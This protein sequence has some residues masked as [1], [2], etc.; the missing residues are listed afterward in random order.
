MCPVLIVTN[1]YLFQVLLEDRE[2]IIDYN[3]ELIS[4]AQMID[5]VE[6]MGFD[7]TPKLSS[8]E[9]DSNVTKPISNP[10]IIDC[11]VQSSWQNTSVSRD[12]TLTVEGMRCKSC[13]RKIEGNM[14]DVPGVVHIA[15]SLESKC[16][17]VT[18]SEN[19]LGRDGVAQK[20]ADL[21]FQVTDS[22]G[23]MFKKEPLSPSKRRPGENTGSPQL[24]R[25][26][27]VA[28]ISPKGTELEMEVLH[29]P[30]K[31]TDMKRCFIEIKGMTCASCVN[32]IERH[33]GMFL[34]PITSSQ[35]M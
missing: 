25:V 1:Q 34:F 18:I 33:I 15:V 7:A 26:P 9:H 27:K 19:V 14:R 20:I 29:M 13:V 22:S 21:G 31:G 4:V 3:P 6:E 11:S 2:G 17:K 5:A 10:P 28:V 30:E 16:A 35:P 12:F 24:P 23:K 8:T 32:N